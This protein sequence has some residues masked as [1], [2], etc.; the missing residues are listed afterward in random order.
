MHAK[1]SWPQKPWIYE[2]ALHRV[3]Y[4]SGG[5]RV[6]DGKR[7]SAS[8]LGAGAPHDRQDAYGPAGAACRPAAF[9]LLCFLIPTEVGVSS[10]I[11]Q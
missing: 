10:G 1:F 6:S 11:V 8:L 2:G 3:I 9:T 7:L 4:G 5:S